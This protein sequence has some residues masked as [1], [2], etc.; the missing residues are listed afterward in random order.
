MESYIGS[1]SIAKACDI[2][3]HAPVAVIYAAG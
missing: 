1:F 3:L 2:E